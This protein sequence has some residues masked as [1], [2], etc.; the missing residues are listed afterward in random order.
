MPDPRALA[1]AAQRAEHRFAGVNCGIMDQMA[2]AVGYPREALL[3]DCRS[4]DTASIAL[5]EEWVVLIVQSGVER[6]LVDG[7][8]NARRGDCEEAAR[9]LGTAS[10]R[11]AGE[12]QVE[13]A[14]LP[15]PL[16][17]RA[18]HVA[19]EIARVK[20]AADAI[21]RGD[22]VSLGSLMRAS[23]ASLRDD[24]AVSHPEVDRIVAALDAAIG[25]EGGA[26]MTGGGFGGA[27]VAVLAR[28]RLDDVRTTL[29]RLLGRSVDSLVA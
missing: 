7:E 3:L 28:E 5:P 4:L 8:Y 18:R 19:S 22:L 25:R 23:H 13:A 9:R 2:I 1:L 14:G 27:V 17:A 6:G 21:T 11:D 16:A 15:G 26:R 24:F 10:L 20:E 29:E 12:A